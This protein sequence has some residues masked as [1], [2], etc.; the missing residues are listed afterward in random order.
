MALQGAVERRR[1]GIGVKTV[2]VETD[3][4]NDS[5]EPSE[6]RNA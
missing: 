6:P 4:P 1:V 3:G 2:V 5:P